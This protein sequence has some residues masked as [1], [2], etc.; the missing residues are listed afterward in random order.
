MKTSFYNFFYDLDGANYIA[1]NS[2]SNSLA[3]MS[4]E[5]YDDYLL[6]EHD[7]TMYIDEGLLD[8]LRHGGFI[9]EDD[10]DELSIIRHSMLQS[11]YSSSHLGLTIAPTADCNFRCIYCY[12]KDKYS[13]CMM[14]RKTIESIINF[15]LLKANDIKTFHVSWYGGEPLLALDVIE[16]LSN[17]FI[18][19]SHEHNISYS[20][21]IITNGYLLTEENAK[22]LA[23][24]QITDCQVT[25]DGSEQQHNINR[26]L[27]SGEGTYTV[28]INNIFGAAPFLKHISVRV[29]S[30]KRDLNA[31]V[32]VLSRFRNSA[33]T[34]VTVYPAPIKNKKGCFRSS[35]CFSCQEFLLFEEQ[36]YDKNADNRQY[37]SK[38]PVLRGNVCVAD[39]CNGFVIA[40]DGEMYKCWSD[41]GC[42]EMSIGNINSNLRNLSKEIVYLKNDPTA[43]ERCSICKLLPIC[44]GGCPYE[45]YN[46]VS[47]RCFTM[48]DIHRKYITKIA[49]IMLQKQQDSKRREQN[50]VYC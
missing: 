14:D 18:Q 28:I 15:V 1:Y 19:I 43:D 41:I 7:N 47:D 38:Y 2:M 35:S 42:P 25:I 8:Q 30:D 23:K 37:C 9:I 13:S 44:M 48:S 39:S 11:R 17:Q 27:L 10:V 40:S 26:P 5:E 45:I 32:D 31:A 29:N 24:C 34:N 22:R 12:E 3:L 33:F 6:F 21:G 49:K 50:E 36:F 20:A 46:G 4:H 16:R